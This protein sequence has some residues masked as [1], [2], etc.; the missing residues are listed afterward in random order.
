MT[1]D[2]PETSSRLPRGRFLDK[3]EL[4]EQL[5]HPGPV[6][7]FRALDSVLG[8]Q[9]ILKTVELEPDGDF[10]VA[11][12]PG[13]ASSS[14][15]LLAEARAAASLEHPRLASIYE[16]GIAD[17]YG[18]LVM[19]HVPGPTL[20]DRLAEGPLTVAECLDL[21]LDLCQA[22]GALHHHNLV[23]CDLSPSN[24]VLDP[25]GARLIDLGLVT[26]A[27]EARGTVDGTP[28]YMAPEQIRGEVLEPTTD[29]FGL[30]AVLYRSLTGVPPFA[31]TLPLDCLEATLH[32]EPRRVGELRDDVPLKLEEAVRR[33]LAKRAVDRF[34]T[35][36]ELAVAVAPRSRPSTGGIGSGHRRPVQSPASTEENPTNGRSG[37]WRRLWKIRRHRANDRPET[38]RLTV[39]FKGLS[40][41][42]ERD[43]DVFF[44][45][46]RESIELTEKILSGGPTVLFGESGCGKTSLLR[47]GVTPLLRD[48]GWFPVYCRA[49]GAP[50][51]SLLQEIARQSMTPRRASES[52]TAFLRRAEGGMDTG[53]VLLVD[54]L[55][56]LFIQLPDVAQRAPFLLFLA[57]CHQDPGLKCRVVMSLRS[58]F[59]Y[60]LQLV[61][62]ELGDWIE[63]PLSSTRTFHLNGLRAADAERVL[64]ASARE[65]GLTL[66]N[67]LA[68]ALAVD[69]ENRGNVRPAELQILGEQLQRLKIE[70]L[71][72][73]RRA[74]GHEALLERYLEDVL[75]ATHEPTAASHV[76]VALISPEE[77]RLTLTLDAITDRC[78]KD[79]STVERLLHHLV[80]A[81]L[82][83]EV[84]KSAPWRYELVHEILIRRILRASGKVV[85]ATARA[86]RVLRQFLARQAVEPKARLPLPDLLRIYRH[87]RPQQ[88][89]TRDLLRSSLRRGSLR[90]GAWALLLSALGIGIAG[91]QS[92]REDWVGTRLREG[93]SAATRR[94]TFSP[95]GKLL[96]TAGEDGEVLIW[97]PA[98]R[99]L[100]TR[101]A[102]HEGWVKDVAFSVDGQYLA[103]AGVDGRVLIYDAASHQEIAELEGLRNDRS[104]LAF[105]PDGRWLV[106]HGAQPVAPGRLWQVGSWRR[107]AFG[108]SPNIGGQIL[109]DPSSRYMMFASGTVWDS[110][111]NAV[112]QGLV[113]PAMIANRGALSADGRVLAGVTPQGWVVF[114]SVPEL[115]SATDR[116]P[117]H[118]HRAHRDIGRSAAF[119]RDGRW[120]ATGAEDIVLWNASTREPLARLLYPSIVWSLDFS[121]DGRTLVSSHGDGAILLWDAVRRERTADLGG[122]AGPVRAVSFSPDGNRLLSASEDRSI[123]VWD[124]ENQRKEAVLV[125]HETRVNGVAA[126]SDGRAVSTDQD[127]QLIVWD[128]ESATPTVRFSHPIDSRD[129]P[130]YAMSLSPNGRWLACSHGVYDLANRRLEVNFHDPKVYLNVTSVYGV[131]FTRDS[132]RVVATSA[133]GRIALWSTE[134]WQLLGDLKVPGV[135]LLDVAIAPAGDLLV[136][137]EDTGAVGL[138]SVEPLRH[139]T[140]LGRHSARVK[141]VTFSADG[142]HVISTGDDQVL[143]LWDVARQRLERRIGNHSSPVLS[144]DFSPDGQNLAAGMHDGTVWLYQRHR[145]RWGRR[146]DGADR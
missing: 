119:S 143:A 86:S 35:A 87:L 59:L 43:C 53:L 114:W 78:P 115:I 104:Q 2:P 105:S 22:L 140:V 116:Q 70:S 118:R 103:S 94:A 142:R 23:H 32:H 40:P 107:Q 121:P 29:I 111:A 46:E 102:A 88:R 98:R 61:A 42:V 77:T 49:Y 93:H 106:S 117:L 26:P 17:G 47:A 83:R 48:R 84:Q 20:E 145:S 55:E 133:L 97:D 96:A 99:H 9:V 92:T 130:I 138:W 76:L 3:F 4:L 139:L 13:E 79:R 129:R 73:Y 10:T 71:E 6:A 34:P 144:A 7:I 112:I 60:R 109:F 68:Q 65:F 51:D 1:I 28:G 18:F 19:E 33:A 101:L 15:N 24:V 85:D 21:S 82:V 131:A 110:K 122:H 64:H 16:S 72:G 123:I 134:S 132:R 11:A 38:A 66:P 80:A 135:P 89:K 12:T 90:V 45:R 54:Q 113:D 50:L 125:G 108:L 126:T 5:E 100:L 81:R 27:G 39:A 141:S 58:D 95:D 67:S 57:D 63:D 37:W 136:I 44:G 62:S 31:G 25:Q 14:H 124:L 146:L 120:L 137:G 52:P 127:G 56:E 91:W 74:G 69:L 8:R 30:G 128:L 41:F 75:R 36:S